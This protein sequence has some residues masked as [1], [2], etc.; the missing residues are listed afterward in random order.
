[1]RFF[2]TTEPYIMKWLVPPLTKGRAP[3]SIVAVAIMV[4]FV[5][6]LSC[7]DLGDIANLLIIVP[8]ASI[9]LIV[10]LVQGPA[11]TRLVCFALLSFYALTS[12]QMMKRWVEIRSDL[13]WV[14]GSR[15]WKDEVLRQPPVPGSGV[16]WVVWDGWGMFAQDTDV[17]LVYSPDDR[18]RQ[19]SPANLAGLPCPVSRVQRLEKAWYSVTFYTDQEWDDCGAA[20][21]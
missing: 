12:W 17:Y 14:A 18:L 2:A 4:A 19:Y 16:K 5:L 6:L 1:M 20:A 8:L 10:L 15:S 11:K 3:F 21:Q 9:A 13:R 7:P